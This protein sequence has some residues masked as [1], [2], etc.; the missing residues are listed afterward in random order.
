MSDPVHITFQPLGETVKVQKGTPLIDVLHEY[1]VEFPCGG[2]GSCGTCKVKLLG[3]NMETG[4]QEAEKLRK[5]RYPKNYRLACYCKATSDITLEVS[6]FEH[7][8]LADNSEFN[9]KPQE[10]AGIAVDLG[11]TTIVAQ[12][13]DLQNGSIIDSVSDVNPQAKFG[14]DLISRI[15]SCLNGKQVDLQKLIREK[16]GEMIQRMLAKHPIHL[17]KVVLVGNTVMQHLFCSLDV[18]PLSM[19]PFESPNLGT[20]I[21]TASELGWEIQP[22]VTIKFNASIGSFVGSDILAGIAATKMAEQEA[23]SIL[24]DLGTNGEIV[25]GNREKI[26]CASTAAG[27]AFEGA[28]I[29]QGMRATTGAI[30]SIEFAG[31]DLSCHVIGNVESRGICGSAL[32]DIMAILLEQQKIGMFGEIESGYQEVKITNNVNLIQ[33]DIREF[34]LAKAAVATG[35]QLL[36]NRLQISMDDVEKIYIAGGFGNFLNL[37]NVIRTGL[38][39]APEEKIHKLGNTALIGAKMFLFEEEAEIQRILDLTTH[40]SLESDPAFQDI[41]IEKMMLV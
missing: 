17:V 27:P 37:K 7:I 31:E 6:Q 2:K 39:E 5:L 23:Y 11:T 16:I 22:D 32:I 1:G 13:V 28:K 4:T 18:Q 36:L 14:A 21:F 33:Q 40:I 25:V 41:Y 20:K 38:I 12:L 24:I 15:E 26:I 8:I 34:Q 30:S 35:V 10:G 9:F 3:G 29:S 19:Y